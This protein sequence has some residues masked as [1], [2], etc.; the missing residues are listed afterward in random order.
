[1]CK[2][3][4]VPD[5]NRRRGPAILLV[6]G[7]LSVALAGCSIRK[8]T[9][10]IHEVKLKSVRNRK[11]NVLLGFEVFNPNFLSVT[12][13]DFDWSLTTKG[14]QLASGEADSS[15]VR[16]RPKQTTVLYTTAGIDV[17]KLRAAAG[18]L[19]K[20]K[21]IKLQ[22]VGKA[23]FSLLG[24]PITVNAEKTASL[25]MPRLAKWL[26]RQLDKA[27]KTPRDRSA[28]PGASHGP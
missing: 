14:R 21:K 3:L 8:P 2:P 1:M 4:R 15:D 25:K 22:V 10:K 23:V 6:L 13:K 27:S 5:S 12:I 7:V 24:I 9:I 11:V 18:T 28:G 16:F 20:D 17:D 19:R 26:T